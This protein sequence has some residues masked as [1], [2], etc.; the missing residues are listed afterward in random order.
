MREFKVKS[1]CVT[2]KGKKKYTTGT[3]VNED[4]FPA[5]N[6]DWLISSGHLIELESEVKCDPPSTPVKT[7]PSDT[8]GDSENT[9]PSDTGGDS[10]SSSDNDPSSEKVESVDVSRETEKEDNNQIGIAQIKKELKERGIKFEK[11][12]PYADLYK[13]WIGG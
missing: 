6:I 9:L 13:L 7:L 3:I 11:N 5:R 12:A 8:G 4:M 10:D 1:L 2:G